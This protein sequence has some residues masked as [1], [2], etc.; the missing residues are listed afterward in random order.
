MKFQGLPL[1]RQRLHQAT[2]FEPLIIIECGFQQCVDHA[3]S[4]LKSYYTCNLSLITE[5]CVSFSEERFCCHPAER[6]KFTCLPYLVFLLSHFEIL[7]VLGASSKLPSTSIFKPFGALHK[8]LQVIEGQGVCCPLL[9][10]FLKAIWSW[11]FEDFP[12]F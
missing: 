4:F 5:S 6:A 11:V 12:R 1:R 7:I 8:R 10:S 9:L 2:T 3:L